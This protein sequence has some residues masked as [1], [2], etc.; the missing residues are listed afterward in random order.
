[1]RR[2]PS[3]GDEFSLY[4]KAESKFETVECDAAREDVRWSLCTITERA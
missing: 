1:M 3:I 4:R 2:V